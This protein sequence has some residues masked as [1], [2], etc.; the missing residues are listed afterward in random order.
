MEYRC[1]GTG[2]KW[3]FCSNCPQWPGNDFDVLSFPSL[4]SDDFNLCENCTA[5]QER[6]ECHC[7]MPERRLKFREHPALIRSGL[8]LWPPHWSNTYQPKEVWPQDEIGTLERVWMDEVL[9]TC[10]FLHMRDDVFRYVGALSFTDQASCMIVFT[11]LKSVVGRSIAE[12]GDLD[13]SHLL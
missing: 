5:L 3:H 8:M 4:S 9:D 2:T 12:I 7:V 13:I 11:F 1:K 6:A 10:V